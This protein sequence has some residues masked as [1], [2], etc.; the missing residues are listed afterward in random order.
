MRATSDTAGK[1]LTCIIGAG[2]SGLATAKALADRGI[3]FECFEK[4]GRIG[5][6]WT[7]ANGSSAAYRSL[8]LN[9]SRDRSGFR[10]FAMPPDFPDFPHHSQMASYLEAYVDQFDLRPRICF[11]TEV[12]S[13]RQLP[14]DR[15]QVS[16]SNGE[17][18]SYDALIVANGHQGP[19]LAEPTLPRKIH[20]RRAA[21]PRLSRSS[22]AGRHARQEGPRRRARQQ[23]D[24]YRL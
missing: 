2:P 8:C 10:D 17:N 15:W 20:R 11:N 21:C 1:P 22:R 6:V 7:F 14:D 5:G 18:R 3:P 9:T 13:A 19:T 24:G 16:L 23:R 4:S 12:I